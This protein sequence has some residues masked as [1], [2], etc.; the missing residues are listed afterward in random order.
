LD[1]RIEKGQMQV[2]DCNQWYIRSGTFDPGKA[3]ESWVE[4]AKE[5]VSGGFDGLR[6]AA[7]A[8][9]VEQRIWDRFMD[10]EEAVDRVIGDCPM[11]AICAYPLDRCGAA[12][13]VEAVSSHQRALV[14]RA[15]AWQ[16]VESAA[17]KEATDR[18]LE[19]ERFLSGV[20]ASIQDGMSVLSPDLTILRVNDVMKRWYEPNLPLE[21]K[22]CY[23]C[24]HNRRE[25]CDLCPTLRCLRSR[26]TEWSVVPALPGSPVKWVEVFS[27]PMVDQG[28]GEATG[29]VE[30]VRDVT[31]R[32]R[33]EAV[34]R[35]SRQQ[36]R[37]LAS[38]LQTVREEERTRIARRIHDELGQAL[39]ALK[40]DL[41]WLMGRAPKRDQAEAAKLRDMV[42]VI[43]ATAATVKRISSEL[44]PGLLDDLGIAAAAE[45][46]L[47]EFHE[48]TGI[49]CE[50]TIEPEDMSLDRE[51]S[52][53]LFRILQEALTNIARHAQASRVQA[54]LRET[55]G[56]VEMIVQDNGVG[57][58]P[59]KTS[60]P[61]SWGIIGMRERVL[62]LN[63]DFDIRNAEGKGTVVRV[64][65]PVSETK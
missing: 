60:H 43:D 28:S 25:P 62:A 58:A 57:I 21:G 17:R 7:S 32:R 47:R 55:P 63:G 34:L 12:E 46:Q 1:A 13:I 50:A 8:F 49:A 41:A 29:V 27:H 38:H 4:K 65:I 39:T 5:A 16:I 64:R 22:K 26:R 3:L 36:F 48:R 11:I 14:K 31:Q 51:R 6:V 35:D 42:A 30:F 54:T 19:R 33:A 10:Y 15:G 24:Y 20:F 9:W 52:T 53:A 18:L 61:Q 40:M 44:R 56:A 23:E 59:E 45:W 37:Q 2:L